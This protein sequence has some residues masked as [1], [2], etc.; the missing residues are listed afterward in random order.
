MTQIDIRP[1]DRPATAGRAARAR[2]VAVLVTRVALA[3]GI[4]PVM[5]LAFGALAAVVAAS[6]RVQLAAVVRRLVRR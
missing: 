5:P 1:T 2:R 6:R 3:L 4:P